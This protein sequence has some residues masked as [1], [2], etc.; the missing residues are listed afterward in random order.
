MGYLAP[1]PWARIAG[2]IYFS[3]L[4]VS[5]LIETL[6]PGRM[7]LAVG[8]IEIA[9]MLSVSLTLYLLFKPVSRSLSLLAAVSNL[10]GIT[11]EAIRLNVHGSDF[12]MVFHGVFCILVGY[13]IW[14]SSLLPRILGVLIALGG[15]AWL[16]Y[17]L[18]PFANYLSPWNVICGLAG[19]ASVFLW[20]LVMS[21]NTQHCYEH[22]ITARSEQ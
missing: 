20:L 13:L 19:E 17:P 7:N 22:T 11:L 15:L 16:T 9:G 12:A 10:V 4:L 21:V 8:L 1:R 5:Q 6:F 2:G 14:R 3:T 18:T